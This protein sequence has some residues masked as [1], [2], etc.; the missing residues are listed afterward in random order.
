MVKISDVIKCVE[1]FAP[2]ELS[3]EFDNCG[4]KIGDADAG[5]TGVLVTVDVNEEVVNEARVKS[6]NLIIEHHPSIWKP[7][8]SIDCSLPLNRALIEAAKSGISIYSAHTNVDYT[9]GGLNDTVAAKM[10]LRGVRR[11]DGP[12]SPRIGELPEETVLKAYARRLADIFDDDGIA[13]IGAPDRTVKRVAVVNG[14]GGNADLL[15]K[16]YSAG[17]DIFVTAEVKH[18]VARLAKDLGYGIIQFGHYSS[19]ADFKPLMKK[20]IE[21]ALPVTVKEAESIGSPYIRRGEIWN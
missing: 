20:I 10:G 6:C 17:A 8:K 4:L 2:V 11:I 3:E 12:S 1:N 19:E 14:G 7:L 16:A 18:S 9:E 21:T 15:W 5:L 13:V